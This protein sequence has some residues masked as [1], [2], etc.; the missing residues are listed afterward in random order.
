M[1][2]RGAT[3]EFQAVIGSALLLA[4]VASG[5]RLLPVGRIDP[6]LDPR[7][8]G[9]PGSVAV[10]TSD[11]SEPVGTLSLPPH[12]AIP[13]QAS[14]GLPTPLLDANLAKAHAVESSPVETAPIPNPDEAVVSAPPEPATV[15]TL[16]LTPTPEPPASPAPS[17]DDAVVQASIIEPAPSPAEPTVPVSPEQAWSDGLASLI[18]ATNGPERE[19]WQTYRALTQWM[20]GSSDGNQATAQHPLWPVALSLL[21]NEE[22]PPDGL[23]GAVRH[24][25]ARLPFAM[26]EMQ[27][28]RK[29]RSFGNYDPLDLGTLH[30]G[31]TVTVYCELEGLRHTDVEGGFRTELASKLELRR[32]SDDSV[33][34]SLDL[35][36]AE[37]ICRKP[38]RDY[39]INYRI[40]LPA[41]AAL[42]TGPYRVVLSLEDTSSGQKCHREVDL[43][44]QPGPPPS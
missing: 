9:P 10:A 30:A 18:A 22:A 41:E 8:L 13:D 23:Q 44:I 1:A 31:Q 2:G 42:P 38:R 12:Q 3:L 4:S 32:P 37:D 43:T 40:T 35:G 39:Y 19:R 24:L 34:W 5:C 26:V 33:V 20:A 6:A 27:L 21:S 36:R 29:V 28:C 7:T 15:P 11:R 16:V 17:R 14:I 25:E